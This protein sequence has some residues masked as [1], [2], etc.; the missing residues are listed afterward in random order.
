MRQLLPLIL[1][2]TVLAVPAAGRAHC[3]TLDGPVV[4]HA[5]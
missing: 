1:A 5:H 2:L 4:T 3:D